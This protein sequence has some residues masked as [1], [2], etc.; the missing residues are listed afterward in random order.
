MVH[1]KDVSIICLWLFVVTIPYIVYNFENKPQNGV[2]SL[3]NAIL[4]QNACPKEIIVRDD[5]T[6]GLLADFCKKAGIAMTKAGRFDP[7]DAL[8]EAM[9]AMIEDLFPETAGPG[10]FAE[11]P[12]E[13]LPDSFFSLRAMGAL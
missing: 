4:K 9:D 12:A 5:R 8:D 13:Y 10:R 6:T 7:L 1:P 3:V 11:S 2:D